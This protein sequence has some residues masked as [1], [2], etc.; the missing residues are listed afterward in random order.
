M[1]N[2][3]LKGPHC[4]PHDFPSPCAAL[5]P[6][7]AASTPPSFP[8]PQHPLTPNFRTSTVRLRFANNKKPYGMRPKLPEGMSKTR[9]PPTLRETGLQLSSPNDRVWW[10]PPSCKMLLWVSKDSQTCHA[11][12]FSAAVGSG[13]IANPFSTAQVPISSHSH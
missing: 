10:L 13:E 12:L 4:I 9:P 6:E 11:G 5:S 3:S 1:R 7:Y 2:S 8:L